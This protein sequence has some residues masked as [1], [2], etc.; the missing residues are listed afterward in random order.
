MNPVTHAPF[1]IITI[2]NETLRRQACQPGHRWNTPSL[3]KAANDAAS[4][5]L[6]PLRLSANGTVLAVD[7]LLSLHTQLL[8]DCLLSQKRP[9]LAPNLNKPRTERPHVC[10]LNQ[11]DNTGEKTTFP[12]LQQKQ[13]IKYANMRRNGGKKEKVGKQS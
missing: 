11:P 5:F 6:S 13:L 10:G 3:L 9:Q 12:R 8:R 7:C 4:A 2:K 1:D